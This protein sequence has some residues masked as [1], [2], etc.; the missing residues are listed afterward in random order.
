MSEKETIKLFINDIEEKGFGPKTTVREVLVVLLG[1]EDGHL[2]L[3]DSEE[4]L[5]LEVML[6][7]LDIRER[8]HVHATRC[9]HIHVTIDYAGKDPVEKT[10]APT[11]RIKA[12]RD[13]AVA[14]SEFAIDP[15]E[16]P[17]FGL[18]VPDEKE[19]LKDVVRIG[20]LTNKECECKVTLELAL[21]ER[22]QG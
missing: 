22:W 9:R 5:G 2:F 13:W 21:R 3:E 12:V 6:V 11:T 10:F 14:L 15:T 4:P 19:P 7:E 20:S 18:F 17:K 1:D 16:R 8:G